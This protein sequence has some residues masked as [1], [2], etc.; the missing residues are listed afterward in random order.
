MGVI[1]L[2]AGKEA[3]AV[4]TA[5]SF[6]G[7]EYK[8]D[9]KADPPRVDNFPT[10]LTVEEQEVLSALGFKAEGEAKK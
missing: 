4:P 7:K 2:V 5:I 3:P 9:T 10:D 1:R 6:R 8:V